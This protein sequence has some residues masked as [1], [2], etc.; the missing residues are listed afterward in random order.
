M[1]E[2]LVK[3]KSRLARLVG[4]PETVEFATMTYTNRR[5]EGVWTVELACVPGRPGV[6]DGWVI[7]PRKRPVLM[8]VEGARRADDAGAAALEKMGWEVER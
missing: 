5:G 6:W 4:L 3:F 1:N 8:R 7:D 2:A